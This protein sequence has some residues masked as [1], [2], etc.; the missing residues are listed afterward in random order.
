MTDYT[1]VTALRSGGGNRRYCTVSGHFE[2]DAGRFPGFPGKSSLQHSIRDQTH[3]VNNMRHKT[4]RPDT[5]SCSYTLNQHVGDIPP[6]RPAICLRIC[7]GFSL[8]FFNPQTAKEQQPR[9][10]KG[11]RQNKAP[12]WYETPGPPH[13]Q[14]SERMSYSSL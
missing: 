7:S 2:E 8:F 1:S 9:T 4:L 6:V 10:N 13:S 12:A 11:C 3:A 5:L 14:R